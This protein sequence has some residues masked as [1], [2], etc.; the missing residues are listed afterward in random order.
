MAD[1]RDGGFTVQARKAQTA[2]TG[3]A[4]ETTRQAAASVL[5]RLVAAIGGFDITVEARKAR[6]AETDVAIRKTREAA[7]AVLARLGAAIDGV[8]VTINPPK[9][10]IAVTIEEEK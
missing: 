10:V 2:E 5:A 8:D 1:G 3:E 7:A 6:F 4:I 9:A